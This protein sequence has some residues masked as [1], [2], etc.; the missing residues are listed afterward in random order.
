MSG[1]DPGE[2][3]ETVARFN[4]FLS[5]D[6]DGCVLWAG[7]PGPKSVGQFRAFGR[8]VLPRR[9]AYGLQAGR[10]GGFPPVYTVCGKS[11]C[12]LPSHLCTARPSP[13]PVVR[14]AT[15]AGV[16]AVQAGDL[17]LAADGTVWRL[18]ERRGGY[19]FPVPRARAEVREV[20]GYLVVPVSSGGRC[21]N[22]LVHR[23][24]WA[25]ANGAIPAGMQINHLDG[26]KWN[27]RLANL[28]LTTPLG[29]TRHAIDVLHRHG[30]LSAKRKAA[31]A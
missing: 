15:A 14:D 13:L 25:C 5:P 3:A 2:L 28:E 20:N 24:M 8:G 4:R 16:L 11:L 19:V 31:V 22:V 12:V 29:N 1:I 7:E 26:D 27:N 17:D 30:S 10:F 18:T 21:F 6:P 23:L 9:F